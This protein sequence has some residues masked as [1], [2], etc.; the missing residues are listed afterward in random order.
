[1]YFGVPMAPRVRLGSPLLLAMPKSRTFTKSVSPRI[2]TRKTFSGLMS[3]CTMGGS[4]AWASPRDFS[5]CSAM[6]STR[7]G[8]IGPQARISFQRDCP[9][10][11]SITRYRRPSSAWPKSKIRIVFTWCRRL[12]ARASR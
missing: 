11:Y 4:I 9:S 10:R 3:R 12:E 7:S 5:T 2:R 8:D 6:R 1:M